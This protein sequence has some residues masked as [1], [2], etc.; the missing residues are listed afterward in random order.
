M[1]K[2]VFFVVPVNVVQDVPQIAPFVTS[3]AASL[4]KAGWQVTIGV[5]DDRTSAQGLL[6]LHRTLTAA[7]AQAQAE[8][9]HAQ[10]RPCIVCAAVILVPPTIAVRS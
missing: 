9:V 8:I 5:V 1:A 10:C 3:Q 7:L 4:Q 2:S 6:R